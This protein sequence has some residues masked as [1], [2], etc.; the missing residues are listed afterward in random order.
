MID[1]QFFEHVNKFHTIDGSNDK[2][3]HN[4]TYLAVARVILGVYSLLRLA[5]IPFALIFCLNTLF[6]MGIEYNFTSWIASVL[7]IYFILGSLQTVA[8]KNEQK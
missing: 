6:K 5:I 7:F 8:P 1:K 4:S 2:S 3:A